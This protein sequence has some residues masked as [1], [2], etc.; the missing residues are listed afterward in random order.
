[1]AGNNNDNTDV[2]IKPYCISIGKTEQ[3]YHGGALFL[4]PV[5]L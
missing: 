5:T 4:F 3:E 2:K 1:M